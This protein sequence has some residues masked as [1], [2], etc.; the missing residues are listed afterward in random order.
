MTHSLLPVVG[1]CNCP[2]SSPKVFRLRVLADAAEKLK[3]RLRDLP[4]DLPLETVQCQDCDGIVVLTLRDLH[5]V[6]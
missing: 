1:R 5:L 6:A 3:E 2:R 4:A